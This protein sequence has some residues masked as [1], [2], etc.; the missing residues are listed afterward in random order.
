MNGSTDPNIA[1]ADLVSE[2]EALAGP[3]P[4]T[5]TLAF[6]EEEYRGRLAG[7]QQ[8]LRDRELDGLLSAAPENLTYISG[9]QTPGYYRWQ[10]MFVPTEGSPILVTR[11]F[12]ASNAQA[13]SWF[14][15][16]VGIGEAER[17][18]EVAARTLADIGLQ[19]KRV[20]VELDSWFLTNRQFG[21]LKELSAGTEWVDAGGVIEELRVIKSPAEIEHI[22]SA[23]RQA[24]AM[25][26]AG[27]DAIAAGNTELDLAAAVLSALVQS[28]G[29]LAGLPPFIVSGP[30]TGIP[31]GTWSER[32]LEPG[33]PVMMELPGTK[34]R[35]CGALL[36]TAFVG[37]ISDLHRR[38]A[39]VCIEG[40]DAA[41]D[42]A[43]PGVAAS[44]V[45]AAM[46]N[47]FRE[48]GFHDAAT[49]RAGYSV[50]VN[51]PPDWGEGNL[52]DLSEGEHRPL[53]PGMTFHV[54]GAL[55]FVG[56]HSIGLSETILITED[57][58]E[59]LT[60]FPREFPV[61]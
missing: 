59:V 28:G 39:D 19:G 44:D 21:E 9:Y 56:T 41:L 30:R 26:R 42:A 45:D 24:E 8:K 57:G 10:G 33:D 37:H 32:V 1:N 36:R 12:E 43:R 6:T 49:H 23:C 17:P 16:V 22:R 3:S 25:M 11:G 53:K 4:L 52:M 38:V 61:L 31:H 27:W 51:W 40:L 18:M 14:D 47:V 55:L 7:L 29:E 34:F 35:Y 5:K 13:W 54:P 20:G 50:G 60:D 46:M 15:D 48:A 2:K 58:C